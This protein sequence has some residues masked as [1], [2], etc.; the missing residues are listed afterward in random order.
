MRPDSPQWIAAKAEG[1]RAELAIAAWF[2]DDRGWRTLKA[3]GRAD[4]DLLLQCEVEVKCDL[5]TAETGNVAIET[6]HRGQPSGIMTSKAAWWVITVGNEALLV[7]LDDLQRFVLAGKFR[8]V[9]AGDGKASTVLLVPWEKL[10]AMRGGHVI[11]L[12]EVPSG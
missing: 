6:H 5:R 11:T 4:F 10:K 8:E 12:P 7:R 3:L 1:D 9:Q 2:R